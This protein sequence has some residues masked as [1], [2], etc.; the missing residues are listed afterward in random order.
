MKSVTKIYNY[1]KKFDYKT[2]VMGASFRNTGQI[3]GLAG[4]DNLTISWVPQYLTLLSLHTITVLPLTT[5]YFVSEVHSTSNVQYQTLYILSLYFNWLQ[6]TVLCEW[7]TLYLECTV[8][9]IIT[10]T[11]YH[12]TSNLLQC[13]L[14]VLH[15][16]N[17][18][19]IH[20]LLWLEYKVVL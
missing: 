18:K 19:G 4:C 3:L 7:I 8:P 13:T 2:I 15:N 14:N 9:D 1:Y 5:V 17:V 12:C 11:Y 6:Y 20:T 16:I 10:F